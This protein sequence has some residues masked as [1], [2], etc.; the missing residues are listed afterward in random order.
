MIS[1]FFTS[2]APLR[3]L[4]GADDDVADVGDAALELALAAAAAKDLDAHRLLRAG[5]VGDV[6]HGLLLNHD[7]F[8]F[9]VS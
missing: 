9:V 6:Q 4:H 7:C 8:S 5:V 2:P 3:L 1:P